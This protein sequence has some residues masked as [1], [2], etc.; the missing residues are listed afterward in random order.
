MDLGFV[1][2]NAITLTCIYGTLAIGL[3]ITWSSLGL[4]NMAYG[5]IFAFAGYGAW[6]F[7]QYVSMNGALVMGAGIAT[8][9]VGGLIVC[10]LAF[11]P[12]HDKPNFTVRGMIATLAISL[13]GTQA[14][15]SFFGPRNKSLPAIF[16]Y[17]R[18]ELG[19]FAVTADKIGTVISAIVLLTLVLMWMRASRRGLEIRAMMMNPNAAALVGIGVRRTGFYVMAVT[20]GLAGLAAVLLAQTYYVNPFGGVTPM[21]KGLAVA[22]LGGLG[23][24]QGAMIAAIV[25][26]LNEA[27]TARY[28]GGQ[29]VLITQFLLIIVVLL[30][31]PRGIAGILD[32]AREA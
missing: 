1:L 29:Y 5:F 28:L 26:G 24:V 11:I 25:L 23:S 18:V 14:L 32:R 9:M 21:I 22:L 19:D 3:S 31:R 6:S 27:V 30:F 8:G 7:A 4:I 15:L 20:G 13:I 16:G 2:V 17:G 10:A 12:I